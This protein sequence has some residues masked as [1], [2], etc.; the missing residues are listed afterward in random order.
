MICYNLSDNSNKLNKKEYQMHVQNIWNYKTADDGVIKREITI[1]AKKAGKPLHIAHLTDLH[2][3]YCNQRDIEE[4]DAVLMSTL[5]H[6]EWLKGGSSVENAVRTL[7]HAKNADAI[8][9]TGDILDYL[10]YGCE[11]LA[12]KYVFEPYPSLIAALGN[13]EAARK[14][15]GVYPEV[16]SYQEKKERLQS[17]WPNALHYSSTVIDERV[18]LIQMD[19]CSEKIGFRAEQIVP[20][21]EDIEKARKNNYIILLF[22][23]VHISP[24]SEKYAETNADLIGDEAWATVNLNRHGI[25]ASH[26]EASKKIIDLIKSSPDVIKA[27]FCG[28]LHS[29]FYCEITANNGQTIPQYLLIGTPYQKGNLLYINIE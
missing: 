11:E 1:K 23:H 3:N 26:G 14:V 21:T 22:F 27:C 12:K 18:M 2:F 17:F 5:E 25:S 7:S 28:H 19:N 16:M 13:H 29:D 8:V 24:E 15:Q 6:R 20:F 4:N 10:S 9:I